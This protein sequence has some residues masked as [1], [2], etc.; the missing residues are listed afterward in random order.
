MN[1]RG[2]NAPLAQ[3]GGQTVLE[4]ALTLMLMVPLVFGFLD[5]S[6]AIYA[7]SVVQWAAQAGARAAIASEAE[8]A[9]LLAI[10]NAAVEERL[11]GLDPEK[12]DV[13]VDVSVPDTVQVDV[14]YQF[15]FIVPFMDRLGGDP[16]LPI[17]LQGSA[18]MVIH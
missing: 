7:R 5:F 16:D 13:G 1:Q 2:P 6:R 15:E 3:E 12:V 14:T 8:S 17:E 9:E 4:F 11:V 18:S 10:V